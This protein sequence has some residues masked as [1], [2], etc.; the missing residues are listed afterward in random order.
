MPTPS[1]GEALLA[2]ALALADQAEAK[3]PVAATVLPVFLPAFKVARGKVADQAIKR[4]KV[5]LR[6][7]SSKLIT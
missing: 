5:I 3:K 7:K 1:Q 4:A 6:S 2:T